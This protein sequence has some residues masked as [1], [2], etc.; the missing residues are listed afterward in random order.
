MKRL[1]YKKLLQWKNSP[2]RLPLILRGARQ[3]GKTYL[4]KAFG[5]AEFGEM[6]YFDFERDREQLAQL[7]E[8]NLSPQQILENLSF[9]VGQRI[10]PET[11][12]LVFD[13]IQIC[14]RA[15]TS[16][17]YFAEEMPEMAVCAAGSLLGTTLSTE[18]FPVGKVTF[19]DLYPM[20][21]E[22]FLL[23]NGNEM[24]YQAFQTLFYQKPGSPI[25]HQKLWEHLKRYYVTGG[26]PGV[27]QTYIKSSN[28][29]ID[30]LNEVRNVQRQL[31]DTYTR[32]FNKHAGKV[33][34][35]HI[36]M[37]FENIPRQISS[38]LDGSIQ[39]YRF[40]DV[41]PGKRRFADLQGPID[42]LIKAGLVHIV[43]PCSKPEL[44]LKAFTKAN[45]FSLRFLD[46]GL[47]GCTLDLNPSTILLENY[48]QSKGFFAENFVACEW[49]ASGESNLY[50][51]EHGQSE[52]EFLRVI[53]N[54]VIPVEV[55]S[56]LRTRAQSLRQYIQKYSPQFAV[57]ITA[58]P[59][60]V[61][62]N[63]ILN[64]PLYAAGMDW[65]QA[66]G[67]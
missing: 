34:A 39:R 52:I 3:V 5:K 54:H 35:T 37:V 50:S 66:I 53:D 60:N 9:V 65:R 56:G 36:G 47:L 13:E 29:E 18:S 11:T 26:M 14:P 62:D 61:G 19:L 57:K 40:K 1:L 59:F 27:V 32:D 4:L 17:K 67:Q 55:K 6:H 12:L 31:L 23:N 49:L 64:I 24:E 2:V 33:N 45:I 48:G 7:F 15:L 58:N 20:N 25:V 8:T 30:R 22:E 21:F 44:P 42:W 43:H 51:W 41:I 46:V 10:D 38:V 63:R 28:A 16:L